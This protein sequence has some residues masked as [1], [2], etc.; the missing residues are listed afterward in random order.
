MAAIHIRDSLSVT[1]SVY[2]DFND[3]LSS[4]RKTHE[5][6]QAYEAK[7]ATQVAKYHAHGK[8][9][10][11]HESILAMMLLSGSN[12]DDGQRI[13]IL[14]SASSNDAIY[15]TDTDADI[16]VRFTYEKVRDILTQDYI[17]TTT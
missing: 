9:L 7:F 14:S 1:S 13:P 2:N 16:V 11:I 4:K 8:P 17:P 10:A 3:L 5:S 12:I 6:Y 15:S